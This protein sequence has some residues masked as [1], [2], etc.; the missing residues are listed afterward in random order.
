MRVYV[1]VAEKASTDESGLLW[2]N[3]AV[4]I[5]AVCDSTTLVELTVASLA[6]GLQIEWNEQRL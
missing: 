4:E 6:D 1:A 2:A 5:L 3:C